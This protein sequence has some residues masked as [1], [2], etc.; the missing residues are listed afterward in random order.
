MKNKYPCSFQHCYI[1]GPTGPT[2]PSGMTSFQVGSVVT[3]P[4]GEDASIQNRGDNHDVI[5]DFVIP[6]GP[7]GE[8]GTSVTILGSYEKEE[9][10]IS[11][12]PTGEKGDSYLVGDN[13]YVWNELGQNWKNVGRIRGPEG[14]VG[15]TG[16]RGIDGKEGEK[17]LAET[18]SLGNVSTVDSNSL[19]RI[20]DRKEGL[21]HTFDF[22]IPRGFDGERGP[23]GPKGEDGKDGVG[24]TI[25]GSYNS[26]DD[27]RRDFPK[28]TRG[29]GYLIGDDL[30]V[31]NDNEQDWKNVGR[32]RGPEGKMGL[33]G[34]MGPQGG[35]G[36]TGPTGP[37]GKPGPEEI[38]VASIV[39]FNLYSSSQGYTVN[40]NERLPLSR[41]EFDFYNFCSINTNDNSITF[42]KDGTYRVDFVVSAYIERQEPFNPSEDFISVGLRR[43]NEKTIY[44]GGSTWATANPTVH[45]IGQGA[46]VVGSPNEVWELVNLSPKPIKLLTPTLEDTTSESYYANPVVTLII[47]FLS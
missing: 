35:I 28:G 19:A 12:H 21:N 20:I 10:L 7:K 40:K 8:D 6:A 4:S 25:L 32:I 34:P 24:V 44:V 41:K 47:Q 45:V 17:G 42:L 5:L 33:Q 11:Q 16:P 3:V 39:T 18:V 29:D 43:Q 30:Y 9:D 36:P 27:L 46:I 38:P 2:G 22:E 13:L 37:Q 1:I 26:I 31:W 23:V 15:P 14:K